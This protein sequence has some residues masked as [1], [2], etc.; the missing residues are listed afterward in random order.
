MSRRATRYNKRDLCEAEGVLAL[1]AMGIYWIE[2]GPLD[3]WIVLEGQFVP[4]EWKMPG[5]PLTEGQQDFINLCDRSGWP[6]R[7]WRSADEAT[8]SVK[9]L[10]E[11]LN[12]ANVLHF[13][14]R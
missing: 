1:A 8:A 3:G 11:H 12:A 4:V 10:R 2:S 7:I 13:R 6:Y 14:A 5:E 9:A